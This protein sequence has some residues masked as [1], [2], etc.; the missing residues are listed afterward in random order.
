MWR[1]TVQG[2]AAAVLSVAPIDP[3]P[4]AA[5][6]DP[7]SNVI[8]MPTPL[9]S[10]GA[11]V[12]RKGVM[13]Q[14]SAIVQDGEEHPTSYATHTF[15]AP[16]DFLRNVRD[17]LPE[18]AEGKSR[19][20]FAAEYN[21]E[22]PAVR[23]ERVALEEAYIKEF[24][25]WAV[26]ERDT[27]ATPQIYY[28]FDATVKT[29][30]QLRAYEHVMARS[31]NLAEAKRA[32]GDID[33]IHKDPRYREAHFVTYPQNQQEGRTAGINGIFG[34]TYAGSDNRGQQVLTFT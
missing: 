26:S 16:I 23:A 4:H 11:D 8:G 20:F 6:P 22:D 1:G 7:V 10:I 30:N 5:V 12:W 18:M 13:Y 9:Y 31:G 27:T 29:S 34:V 14:S 32:R 3:D 24:S 33:T 17:K 28:E 21:H 2:T 19:K 15:Q 25:A